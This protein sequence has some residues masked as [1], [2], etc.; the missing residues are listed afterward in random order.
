MKG[1]TPIP[2][3]VKETLRLLN[4]IYVKLR[5]SLSSKLNALAETTLH[6]QLKA[7]YAATPDQMER[8]YDGFRID[9][10]R[11]DGELVEIQTANFGAIRPKLRRLIRKRKVTLVHPICQTKYIVNV[12][13][14]SGKVSSRRKSP[15]HGSWI[16]IFQELVYLTEIFPSPNLSLEI[17]LTEEEERRNPD[18]RTRRRRR[19]AKGERRLIKIHD[20]RTLQ[21]PEDFL[22]FIP[23]DTPTPFT[24]RGLAAS[25]GQEDRIARQVVYCLREMNLI[26]QIGKLRNHHLYA[27]AGEVNDLTSDARRNIEL[28]ELR[29]SDWPKYESRLKDCYGESAESIL[30]METNLA[31][32]SEL[33]REVDPGRAKV[34]LQ[35]EK[36]RIAR[37]RNGAGSTNQAR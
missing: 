10:V 14:K 28:R 31:E 33:L 3:S 18:K 30:Q 6:H 29:Q 23:A 16:D 27:L 24:T 1:G 13:E 12:D 8:V 21:T 32:L 15:K 17:L 37:N 9:A 36:A 20:R 22:S 25:M 5:A 35:R 19:Q 4:T 34:L 2:R 7:L 26:Q 11:E